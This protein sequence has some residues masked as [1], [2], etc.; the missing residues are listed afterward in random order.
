MTVRGA[1]FLIALPV[2]ICLIASCDNMYLSASSR[3]GSI[4]TPGNEEGYSQPGPGKYSPNT[5]VV[6]VYG[7]MEELKRY[8]YEPLSPLAETNR[9]GN[10]RARAELISALQSR[11]AEL[12]ANAIAITK[13]EQRAGEIWRIR[14]NAVRI[15]G[16]KEQTY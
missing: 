1:L 14:A 11:A 10:P 5:G 15:T 12:G 3:G 16:E 13:E 2:G 4:G 6:R 9:A 7:S 8:R